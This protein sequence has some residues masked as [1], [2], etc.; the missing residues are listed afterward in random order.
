[1]DKSAD[2][3]LGWR[4]RQSLVKCFGVDLFGRISDVPERL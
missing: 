3:I 2:F 4:L 1:L